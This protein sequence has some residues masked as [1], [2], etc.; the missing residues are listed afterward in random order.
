MDARARV[1][2]NLRRLRAEKGLSQEAF[3]V[4]VELDRTYVSRI[5]RE[6]ENPSLSV[7]ERIAKTLEVDVVDIVSQPASRARPGTLKPGRKR[8]GR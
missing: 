2:R 4:D 7:L 5:E 6:L 8:G 3:A 1:A